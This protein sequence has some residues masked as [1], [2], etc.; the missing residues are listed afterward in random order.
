MQKY[1]R[2]APMCRYICVLGYLTALRG[3]RRKKLE[4]NAATRL[5]QRSAAS[6]AI[7]S[8]QVAL[9]PLQGIQKPEITFVPS[10]SVTLS[11]RPP[12]CPYGIAYRRLLCLTAYGLFTKS[13]LSPVCGAWLGWRG[14]GVAFCARRGVVSEN[15]LH[16]A[17]GFIVLQFIFSLK[18][19]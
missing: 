16:W 11:V 9:S 17:S 5:A 14:G 4:S 19:V 3:G 1:T 10:S 18:R 7:L 15:A 6:R 2:L 8:A 13:L 12:L